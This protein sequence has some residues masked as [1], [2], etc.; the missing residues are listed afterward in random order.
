MG[1]KIGSGCDI[2]P[3]VEFGSEPYLI[4]IGNNVRI[5][6]GVRFIT[7]DGGV[8]TLRKARGLKNI[9][10]FGPIS[11]GDNST[12]GWNAI[13]MP[14]VTIG[15]N[16]VVGAGAVVTHNVAENSIVAGV[17]AKVIE[18]LDEYYD[19]AAE[20]GDYTKNMTWEQKKKYLSEKYGIK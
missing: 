1:G 16:C 3:N 17:P 10:V 9:D 13:I 7:H 14:G 6:S 12:I 11:V 4:S 15:K 8:W 2:H 20:T 18:T 5:T 19:K